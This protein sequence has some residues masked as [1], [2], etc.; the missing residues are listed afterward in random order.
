M[1]ALTLFYE[2]NNSINSF[3]DLKALF[4]QSDAKTQP[5]SSDGDEESA[6]PQLE[7][8]P[9][10]EGIKL[11][12]IKEEWQTANMFF[13]ANLDLQSNITKFENNVRVFQS[14]IYDY[15]SLID[16]NK[17]PDWTWNS[18]S[19]EYNHL[20][21][22]Q[23]KRFLQELKNDTNNEDSTRIRYVSKLTSV[24]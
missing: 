4:T 18:L 16:N 7:K 2:L 8:N 19:T 1:F 20:S 12:T 23:L 14:C 13:N 5:K 22:R 9:V 6:P 15:F 17:D 11:P 24:K 10:K 3:D 21:R